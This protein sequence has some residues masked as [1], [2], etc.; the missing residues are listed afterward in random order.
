[1]HSAVCCCR[2]L[3][4]RRVDGLVFQRTWPQGSNFAYNS[5]WLH[6]NTGFAISNC[7]PVSNYSFSDCYWWEIPRVLC[8]WGCFC[9]PVDVNECLY[10]RKRWKQLSSVWCA[11]EVRAFLKRYDFGCTVEHCRNV[12]AAFHPLHRLC[13]KDKLYNFFIWVSA[14]ANTRCYLIT[15]SHPNA[16]AGLLA[17][18][19]HLVCMCIQEPGFIHSAWLLKLV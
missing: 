15:K 6:E 5:L 1:M 18:I 8:V 13:G 17:W 7:V 12:P 3:A 9:P 11:C 4:L 14:V 16:W 19:P 2:H 10:Y